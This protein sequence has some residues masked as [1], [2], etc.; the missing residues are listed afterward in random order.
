MSGRIV[1][2]S[3][4]PPEFEMASTTSCAV[5]MPRSPWLASPGC[6]KNAGVPALAS[7]AA[8]LRPTWPDLPMPVTTMRPRHASMSLQASAKLLPTRR[9]REA[10]ALASVSMTDTADA[11]RLASVTSAADGRPLPGVL[12]R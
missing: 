6:T 7:V 5:I 9:D 1:T 2:I 12:G 3:L 10:S 8:I 4:V 11:Q